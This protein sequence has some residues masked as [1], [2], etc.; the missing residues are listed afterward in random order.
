MAI[1]NGRRALSAPERRPYVFPKLKVDGELWPE[2]VS[3]PNRGQSLLEA[4][5][6]AGA[7]IRKKR[8]A[9]A[10]PVPTTGD[11]EE[12]FPNSGTSAVDVSPVLSARDLPR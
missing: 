5:Q 12:N 3:I 6:E 1:R 8:A 4:Q 10:P 2:E 7:M 9:M 11:N